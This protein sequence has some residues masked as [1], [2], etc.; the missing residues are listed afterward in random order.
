[1]ILANFDLS[2]FTSIPGMLI[3]GGVLL[4][5]IALV[6][7]I[8]T[9]SKKDKKKKTEAQTVDD[10]STTVV[11]STADSTIA[12]GET[13][14]QPTVVPN[15]VGNIPTPVV[16]PTS[17][18]QTEPTTINNSP[19]VPEE[20][21]SV[22]TNQEPLAQELPQVTAEP[23]EKEV[24]PV[25]STPLETVSTP[26]IEQKQPEVSVNNDIKVDEAPTITIVNEEGNKNP[27][28][29]TS[30]LS[31]PIY[32]GA[33]PVIPKIEVEG[34]EHRPI[35]GGAN[36]LENTGA[37]PTINNNVIEPV[38]QTVEPEVSTNNS[39]VESPKVEAESVSI[40]V[41]EPTSIKE[42]PPV[43]T[44][45]TEVS[46]NESLATEPLKQE[47]VT[48]TIAESVP[49]VEVPSTPKKEEEIESLF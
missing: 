35:Y 12:T 8:A 10:A 19:I 39:V 48:P 31:K 26:I 46:S 37:I 9:G 23:V 47:V 22:I 42:E 7:F 13:V 43:V 2:F 18:V 21:S 33:E 28:I 40:P 29:D 49:Q 38:I 25:E 20:S 45:M 4:L 6:I 34:N 44:P 17:D 15:D 16:T 27:V 41:V 3:T 24:T 14:V 1:M 32:G 30:E 36:P 5:L 11:S